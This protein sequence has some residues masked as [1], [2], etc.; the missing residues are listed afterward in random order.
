MKKFA[1]MLAV[2]LWST[3]SAGEQKEIHI[4]HGPWLCDMDAHGVTVVWVTD[5]PALS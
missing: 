4:T 2:V 1:W 5:R 3:V